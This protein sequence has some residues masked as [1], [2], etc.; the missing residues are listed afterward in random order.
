MAA[1]LVPSRFINYLRALQLI[2]I[3]KELD[4]DAAAIRALTVEA[5]AHS[6]FGHSGEADLIEILRQN[7]LQVSSFVATKNDQLVGHI[8]FSPVVIRFG[9]RE[10]QGMGLG[11]MSVLPELQRQGI[12]KLLIK[13]G[14][15]YLAKTDCSLVVVI[16]HPEYYPQ[17][18]FVPGSEYQLTHAF[19]GIPQEV[20]FVKIFDQ[21]SAADLADGTAY[22]RF[23]FGPQ[24]RNS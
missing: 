8:M 24:E 19:D 17:F 10:I 12:G 22:Y 6:E 1:R 18:G 2:E 15:S 5:F 14:L 9:D 23:E 7:C 20:F 3:R 21:S 13:E 16:G 11:P 4:S